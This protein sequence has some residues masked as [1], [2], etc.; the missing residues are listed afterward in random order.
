M[1]LSDNEKRAAFGDKREEELVWNGKTNEVC[2]AVPPL[3]ILGL[4][5]RS[6]HNRHPF[7]VL[8]AVQGDFHGEGEWHRE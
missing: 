8:I 4:N 7:S 6:Q 3:L 2:N 5:A 1:N